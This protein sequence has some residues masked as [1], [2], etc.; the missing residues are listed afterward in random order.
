[1]RLAPHG[2]ALSLAEQGLNLPQKPPGSTKLNFLTTPAG[3]LK[4]PHGADM[5]D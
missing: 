1:V 5:S 3:F 2:K 4:N